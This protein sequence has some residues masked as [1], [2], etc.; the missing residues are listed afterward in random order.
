[1]LNVVWNLSPLQLDS[2]LSPAE[3][4]F[5]S[6]IFFQKLIKKIFIN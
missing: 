2:N 6:K 1:M 5:E 4:G 3:S